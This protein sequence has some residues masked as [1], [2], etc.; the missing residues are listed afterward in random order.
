MRTLCGFIALAALCCSAPGWAAE[1]EPTDLA[2]LE[3]LPHEPLLV[4]SADT[5]NGGE[6][7]DRVLEVVRRFV[8]PEVGETIPQGIASMNE[9][10]GIDLRNDLLSHLGPQ[11]AVVLDMQP[12]DWS[13]G[14][15]MSGAP[16]AIA[17][18]F[19]ASGLVVQTTDGAMVDAALR[20]MLTKQ[21]LQVEEL[22]GLVHAWLPT[23]D[24]SP[25]SATGGPELHLYWGATDGIWAAGLAPGAVQALLSPDT[26]TELL[27]DTDDYRRVRANLDPGPSSLTYVNLPKLHAMLAES[28]MVHSGLA[29]DP[30]VEWLLTVLEDPDLASS[31]WG[32]VTTAVDDGVRQTSWGPPWMSSGTMTMGIVSAIAIPNLMNAVNRGRQKRTMADLRTAALAIEAHAVDHNRYPGPTDGWVEIASIHDSLV[33]DYLRM[34]LAVDGWE[35]AILYRSDGSTYVLVSPGR[36]GALSQDWS[37]YLDPDAGGDAIRTSD[38]DDDIVYANGRFVVHPDGTPAN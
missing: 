17:Q 34:G 10:L 16:T 26:E 6:M 31:G 28:G 20:R 8:P 1:P 22:D 13:V 38:F 7:F 14:V 9:G 5:G 21:G 15:F 37:D 29:S 3:R 32:V 2:L 24:A 27:A 19:P 33:P 4:W 25:E 11:F 18:V 30:D 12:I 35:H 23:A 36:D